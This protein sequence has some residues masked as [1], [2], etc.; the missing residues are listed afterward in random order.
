M[1]EQAP[2]NSARFAGSKW[3]VISLAFNLFLVGLLL[4]NL[5]SAPFRF[6]PPPRPPL[7]MMLQEASGK[8]SPEGLRKLSDLVDEL[9][10]KF[11]SGMADA[12]GLRDRI[13]TVLVQESFDAAAFN[14]ILDDLNGAFELDRRTANRRF[15]EVI[16]TLSLSDRKELAKIRFP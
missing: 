13:R 3:L 4:G 11:R 14:K 8:V 6:G 15:A 12:G 9:E 5:L 2:K 1:S 16:A 7:Q 10:F